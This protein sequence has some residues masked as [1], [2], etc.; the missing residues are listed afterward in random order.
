MNKLYR[1]ASGLAA[2][3]AIVAMA[4]LGAISPAVAATPAPVT[5]PYPVYV[6][7]T[8]NVYDA[9]STNADLVGQ[10]LAGQTWFVLGTDSTGKWT[11][12]SITPAGV[13]GWVASSALSLS[14]IVLPQIAGFTGS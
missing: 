2:T 3:F 14:G 6:N 11:Q 4:G 12:V 8:T 10:L 7:T 9:P 1:I 5:V 13:N